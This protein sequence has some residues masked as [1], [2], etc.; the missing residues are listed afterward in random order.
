MKKFTDWVEEIT[1]AEDDD[2][3]VDI[4][5][6]IWTDGYSAGQQDYA[7]IRAL[8]NKESQ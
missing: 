8:F 2:V 5:D 7:E 6:D 3:L 4:V 1:A